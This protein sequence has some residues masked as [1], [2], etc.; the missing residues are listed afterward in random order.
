[1]NGFEFF[2]GE[3]N[4]QIQQL[5]LLLLIRWSGDFKF[6]RRDQAR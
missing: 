4:Y 2:S 6:L 5:R 3:C 1:M